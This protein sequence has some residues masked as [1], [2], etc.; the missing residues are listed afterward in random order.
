MFTRNE[1]ERTLLLHRPHVVRTMSLPIQRLQAFLSVGSK[2]SNLHRFE[3]YGI[4]WHFD[5][6]P[7]IQ[8]LEEHSNLFG[9]I[10][11][12]KFAGPNDVRALQKPSLCGM[13]KAIKNP[14]LIDLSRYKEATKDLEVFEIQNKLGLEQLLFS[15]EYVP[16]LPPTLDEAAVS[17]ISAPPNTTSTQLNQQPSRVLDLIRQ[18]P[19]MSTLQ[20]GVQSSTAFS[21]ARD[22]FLHNPLSLQQFKVLHLSA[23]RAATIKQVLEDCVFAFQHSLEDLKGV[24]LKLTA[25]F[26]SNIPQASLSTFGWSWP[27]NR[28][29]VLYLKGELAVWFDLESLK[30]CPKLTEIIFH[31]QPYSPPKEDHLEKL[32]LAQGLKMLALVGRWF[33]SDR[34]MAKLGEGLPKLEQLMINGCQVDA[35][36]TKGLKRGLDKMNGLK[37]LAIELG[38][39]PDVDAIVQDYRR[40]RPELEIGIRSD[41]SSRP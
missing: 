13:I 21:W 12:V 28:L 8:F 6:N 39:G 2:L 29:S 16:P 41:D 26:Q 15:L 34:V 30:F 32:V 24:A 36:T 9:T 37:K 14:R 7:A 25:V 35:L 22:T 5:L 23:N 33:L 27:L 20:M 11:E 40:T 10:R 1:I 38:P 4:S 17:L 18:C 31:L 3:L 19:N